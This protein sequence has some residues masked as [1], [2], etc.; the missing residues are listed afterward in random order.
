[1]AW[2]PGTK[3]LPFSVMEKAPMGILVGFTDASVGYG[4]RIV[5]VTLADL[6]G[7]AVLVAVTVTVLGIGR[8]G[9]GVYRPPGEIVPAPVEGVMDQPTPVVEV[10]LTLA[11][12]CRNVP[13]WT[14][15]GE[16]ETVTTIWA[17]AGQN[18]HKLARISLFPIHLLPSVTAPVYHGARPCDQNPERW[19]ELPSEANLMSA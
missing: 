19:Q 5:T 10:P 3:P 14:A 16:G 8:A 15:A 4:F 1:M 11:E 12:S 18:A 6:A 7:L 17:Y 9:G 2:A 13:R